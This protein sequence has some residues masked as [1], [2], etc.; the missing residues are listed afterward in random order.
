MTNYKRLFTVFTLCSV[1][2]TSFL[3]AVIELR[4]YKIDINGRSK[5]VCFIAFDHGDDDRACME[6]ITEVTEKNHAEG[7]T[8]IPLLLEMTTDKAN[9]RFYNQQQSIEFLITRKFENRECLLSPFRTIFADV[10][11]NP[12]LRL[13]DWARGAT[14]RSFSTQMWCGPNERQQFA[15]C[16]TPETVQNVC[17]LTAEILQNFEHAL[18]MI[19][20]QD[21]LENEASIASSKCRSMRDDF[22]DVLRHWEEPTRSW[23]EIKSILIANI[24]TNLGD[25][26]FM[27]HLMTELVKDNVDN[28]I[29]VA[30]DG[31]LTEDVPK[32]L[33]EIGAVMVGT[34]KI[35]Q[36]AALLKRRAPQLYEQISRT[37]EF[38]MKPAEVTRYMRTFL[39]ICPVCGREANGICTRCYSM[40]YCSSECQAQDW[41]THV[42][43]CTARPKPDMD[44]IR[45]CLRIC[46]GCGEEAKRVCSRC[47]SVYYCSPACQRQDWESHKRHCTA[48]R[49]QGMTERQ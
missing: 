32:M 11:T 33:E 27:T 13:H 20:Q 29:L 12:F 18:T 19:Y 14:S 28:I 39:W 37:K 38:S 6:F 41:E 43:H 34:P 16:P 7:T 23:R 36:Q 45:N 8:E 15:Y 25:V 44:R 1:L 26:G 42:Q 24:G 40:Y 5:R 17:D 49:Q 9:G 22:M 48:P 3:G 2:I 47:K 35:S 30:G 21:V 10:R 31:H 4:R 46:P